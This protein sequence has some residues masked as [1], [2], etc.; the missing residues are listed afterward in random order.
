M[1]AD[2]EVSPALSSLKSVDLTIVLGEF[3]SLPK[4]A[5]NAANGYI[6]AF[7]RKAG[8]NGK[9]GGDTFVC[10]EHLAPNTGIPSRICSQAL[11]WQ[12]FD[13]FLGFTLKTDLISDDLLLQTARSLLAGNPEAASIEVSQWAEKILAPSLLQWKSADK[14]ACKSERGGRRCRSGWKLC[15][16]TLLLLSPKVMA[17]NW[18]RRLSGRYPLLILAHHLVSDRP[19]RMGVPTETFWRQVLFLKK[20]YRIVSLFEGSELLRSGRIRVPTVVLT[21]DDGYSDNFL[22]LRAVTN[23]TQTPSTLFITT[24]PVEAHREFDHDLATGTTGFLP[25]TW[26]QITHWSACGAEFGSHTR[27]HFDCGSSSDLENLHF[28]I[29]GSRQDLE[30]HLKKPVTFFAFPYGKQKNM[31]PVAMHL[32]ATTYCH[33]LSS[34]GGET[35]A[36]DEKPQSH[37]FRKKFYGSPWELELELQSV[38][39]L[40]DALKQRFCSQ[41]ALPDTDRVH[42]VSSLSPSIQTISAPTSNPAAMYSPRQGPLKG[43]SSRWHASRPTSQ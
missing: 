8:T 36:D 39:D 37:L 26:D 15:I 31:S 10:I 41:T 16:D 18:Y 24:G 14:D 27:T 40:V 28:E 43:E 38:F 20:H 7:T 34:F 22:G 1:S 12:P 33:Y 32:A 4:F 3:S 9:S 23:E 11:P 13:G 19:H 42:A 35:L 25:L 17:R 30:A 29:I 21:F 6:R 2:K 5:V